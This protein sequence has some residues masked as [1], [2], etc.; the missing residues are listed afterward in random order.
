MMKIAKL[1]FCCL[2]FSANILAAEQRWYF[3]RHFEKMPGE[4]PS[5]TVQGTQRAQELANYFAGIPLLAIYS[6]DY[7]RTLQTAAPVADKQGLKIIPYKPRQLVG[8]AQK[9]RSTSNVLVVGHSNTTPE[10]ISLMGGKVTAMTE[11]D[12]GQLFIVSM[13][14]G[15]IKTQVMDITL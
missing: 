14:E 15:K 1:F 10:L 8:L 3:V 11:S 12:Y 9:L 4:N 2:C 13:I 6:T 5:L 7:H